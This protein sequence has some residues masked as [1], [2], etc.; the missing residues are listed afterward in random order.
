VKGAAPSGSLLRGFFLIQGLIIF[1]VVATNIH[2]HWTPNGCIPAGA[3]VL[4]AWLSTLSSTSLR[5]FRAAEL[6]SG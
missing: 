5:V 3:G 1:A 4:L 2:R 6:P